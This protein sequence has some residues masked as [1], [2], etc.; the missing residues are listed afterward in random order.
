MTAVLP[1]LPEWVGDG[2]FNSTLEGGKTMSEILVGVDGTDGGRDAL[3]FARRLAVVTGARL[4]LANAFPYDDTHTRASNEA[5]RRALLEDAESVLAEADGGGAP[6]QARASRRAAT[7]RHRGRVG[8][9]GRD[10]PRSCP[11]SPSRST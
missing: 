5:F 3:A 9:R 7:H 11:R 10:P 6:R 2:R 8:V 1:A 4:R